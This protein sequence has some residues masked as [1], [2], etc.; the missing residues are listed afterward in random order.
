M[1]FLTFGEGYHNYHHEFQHDYDSYIHCHTTC[2]DALHGGGYPSHPG[3]VVTEATSL[4]R[5]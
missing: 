2:D 3:G 5:H 4:Y 1:A